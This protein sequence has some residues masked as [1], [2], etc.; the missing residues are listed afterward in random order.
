MPG[1]SWPTLP[2]LANDQSLL[3]NNGRLSPF[4]GVFIA[5][6]ASLGASAGPRRGS[7]RVS[8]GHGGRFDED[9]SLLLCATLEGSSP[10][11]PVVPGLRPSHRH[12]CRPPLLAPRPVPSP[13]SSPSHSSPHL[14]SGV[15]YQPFSGAQHS[16]AYDDPRSPAFSRRH[17]ASTTLGQRLG[18]LYS[19]TSLPWPDLPRAWHRPLASATNDS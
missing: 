17:Q 12:A 16:V 2:G 1:V 14:A 10:T 19:S 8:R 13:L 18:Y 11:R 5:A 7:F 3:I 6:V 9:E 15:R 4:G